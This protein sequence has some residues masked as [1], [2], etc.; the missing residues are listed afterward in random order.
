MAVC[1]QSLALGALSSR[2]VLS[3]LV[4]VL[5]KKFVL[6]LNTPRILTLPKETLAFTCDGLIVMQ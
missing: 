1:C 5:L 6:F 4:G 3:V 2:S